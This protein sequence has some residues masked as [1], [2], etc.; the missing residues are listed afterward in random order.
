M[1]NAENTFKL[2]GILGATLTEGGITLEGE[3][4]LCISLIEIAP[5]INKNQQISI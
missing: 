5:E 4:G 1:N 3:S 2:H